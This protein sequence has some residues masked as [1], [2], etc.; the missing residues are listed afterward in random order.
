MKLSAIRGEVDQVS[1]R[2]EQGNEQ[3]TTALDFGARDQL[4]NHLAHQC[5]DLETGKVADAA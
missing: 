2:W 3:I 4:K 5:L 1:V